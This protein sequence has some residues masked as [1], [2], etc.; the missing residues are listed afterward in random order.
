[1]RGTYRTVILGREMRMAAVVA[2]S[3]AVRREA[4][5]RRHEVARSSRSKRR[6]TSGGWNLL[7]AG[8]AVAALALLFAYVNVYANLAAANCAR[9]KLVRECRI[10]RIRN[11]RLKV[12]LAGA[13]VS[14]DLEKRVAAAGMVYASK[15]DYLGK[16]QTVARADTEH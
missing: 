2:R 8:A 4:A 3:A 5:P 1:M 16:A 7:K 15:Y 11:E 10:E 14:P 9:A 13:S 6:L 12:Q